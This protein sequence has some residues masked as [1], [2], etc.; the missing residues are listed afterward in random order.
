MMRADI[1]Q[2]M[3][4]LAATEELGSIDAVFKVVSL[5]IEIY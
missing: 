5:N 4:Q 1:E 3:A 2:K